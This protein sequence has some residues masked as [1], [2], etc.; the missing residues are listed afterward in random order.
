MEEELEG[1]AAG[2]A[3]IWS[4]ELPFLAEVIA[5]CPVFDVVAIGT[6]RGEV[7]A[8]RA[9]DLWERLWTARRS[10]ERRKVVAIAWRPD[11]KFLVAAFEDGVLVVL[12]GNTGEA[13]ERTAFQGAHSVCWTTLGGRAS[14]MPLSASIIQTLVLP[15]PPPLDLGSSYE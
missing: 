3:T 11:G 10:K 5:L 13:V 12:D 9:N 14:P 6:Q 1:D 4:K 15:L 8:Y 2:G 7:T